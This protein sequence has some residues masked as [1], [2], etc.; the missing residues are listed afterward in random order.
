VFFFPSAQ[1]AETDEHGYCPICGAWPAL[2][3]ARGLER[4]RRLRCTRCGGDWRT[5]WL[6]CPYCGVRDHLQLGAL[7]PEGAVETR[8]AETCAACRRY[9]KTV[10]TLAATPADEVAL[11]DLATLE[12][13]LAA[14]THGYEGPQGLGCAMNV[15]IT[16]RSRW[17]R[18][19]RAR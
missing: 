11:Q 16:A 6:R 3:E 17:P 5:E 10:T 15:R 2:A 19:V 7:A 4:E 8:K 9:V 13:D 12:L 14:L 18:L 1:V